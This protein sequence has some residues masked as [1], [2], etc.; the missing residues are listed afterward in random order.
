MQSIF[1]EAGAQAL[2]SRIKQLTPDAQAGWGRMNVS[3]ML[4]HC[5]KP[6]DT[7]YDPTYAEKYPRPNALIRFFLKLFIKPIVVGEK[8]YKKNARTAPEFVVDDD[9]DFATEQA[10]LIAYVQQVYEAGVAEFDGKD[11]HSFGPLTA[12]EWDVL[13]YKHT[14]YH[15]DQFGV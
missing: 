10:R 3:Q 7:I 5:C 13:F 2:I 11:S 6:F 15:L 12:K 4:A 1:D 8:P 14:S 9:R